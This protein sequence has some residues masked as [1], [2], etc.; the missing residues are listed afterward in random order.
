MPY[1]HKNVLDTEQFSKSDLDFLIGKIRDMERLANNVERSELTGK[2]LA[3]RGFHKNQT[4][5][6]SGDGTARR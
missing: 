2:L 1:N 5:F 4:F 3:S 6:R